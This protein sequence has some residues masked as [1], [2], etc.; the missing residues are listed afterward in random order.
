MAF[1]GLAVLF[2]HADIGETHIWKNERLVL[3]ER[4]VHLKSDSTG[5]DDEIIS[6]Q[7]EIIRLDEKIFSSYEETVDRVTGQKLRQNS[8]DRLVVYLALGT[9]LLAL[10]FVILLFVVRS[11]IMEREHTGLVSFFQ[12]L[13]IEF[14]GK[15]S[16]EK[17]ATNRVLRVNVVVIAGL[18]LMSVSILSYL[19]RSL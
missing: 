2:A 4:I 11:R 10:F 14:A 17:S 3:Q 8:N 18:I 19:I 15:V 1:L 13:T 16:A 6:L 7:Q 9:S 5:H 12:Q